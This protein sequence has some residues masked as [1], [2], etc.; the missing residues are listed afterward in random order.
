MRSTAAIAFGDTRIDVRLPEGTRTIQA[1]PP[2]AALADPEAAL[3]EALRDPMGHEPLGKLVGS[4]ARVTIAFDDP[5]LPVTPMAGPDFREMAIPLI[6]GELL[7]A[8]VSLRDVRLLC[9]NALHRKWTRRELATIL[10]PTIPLLWGPQRLSCHDAE[11]PD[12]L[13][14]L[15]ETERGVEVEVNRAVLE[16]DLFIYVNITPTPMNGGWKSTVVGLSSFRSIRHHHR[17]FP[18]AGHSIMDAHR[19]AFQKILWEMGRLLAGE[20]ARK[21][22][23]MFQVES[24]LTNEIP[25]RLAVVHAGDVE[26]V[27]ARILERVNEQLVVDVQ[28]Q[29]DVLLI[30][31]PD[32]D[33]YSKLSVMNPL[34]V[35]NLGLA[36]SFGLYQGKPLVREGGILILASPC[37]P[38]WN[39]IH[40]PSY[41]EFYESVIPG[42]ADPFDA[43][44]TFS[45][46]FAHRPEYVHKYRHAFGFH[47]VHPFF[48]WN[49]RV[50][51]SRHLSRMLL[52][53]PEDPE[54]ARRLGFEPFPT[55]EAAF[56]EAEAQLGRGFTATY[57]PLPPVCIPRVA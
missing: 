46:D 48:M 57:L 33:P 2:L 32:A 53:G 20:L 12:G 24:V 34:L 11:D 27:H 6:L 43:W 18:S 54:V 49:A 25:A 3:R 19:S 29:T 50:F 36:Y 44:D 35:H 51:P 26:Q 56:A 21:G 17:P 22:R 14:F 40:H 37:R 7:E 23:K 5:T 10:G 15:G 9:A 4:G 55:V 42:S 31:L 28:G 1:P 8:G 30:G 47:G 45:D 41:P 52:A 38:R 13:V 16:S 39:R